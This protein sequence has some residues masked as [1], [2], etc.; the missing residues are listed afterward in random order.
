MR[1]IT[2]RTIAASLFLGFVTLLSACA[3]EADSGSI[4]AE[5]LMERLDD[6]D[7][8]IVLDVRTPG[9]YSRGHVP[10][11]YNLPDQQ[12]PA[13]IEELKQLKDREIVIYCEVG[14]RARWVE[15][16]LKNQGFTDIKHL[17]GDMAGWRRSG[18]P[19]E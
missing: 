19:V 17:Q 12:V 18:L 13:R 16:Y 5:E 15:S 1:Y 2:P 8:P 6:A 11:A 4:R 10:G 14:P 7:A 9:E 3:S